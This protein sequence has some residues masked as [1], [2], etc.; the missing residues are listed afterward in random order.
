MELPITF[1][2]S[3]HILPTHFHVVIISIYQYGCLRSVMIPYF[4]G[5]NLT[6]NMTYAVAIVG[7][8]H[9]KREEVVASFPKR[10][11]K[12]VSSLARI[13]CE[14]QSYSNKNKQRDWCRIGDSN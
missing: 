12:Q 13:V 3:L 6:M 1:Q 11:V 8:D 9:F 5:E 10:D 7:I 4:V 14:L 2:E